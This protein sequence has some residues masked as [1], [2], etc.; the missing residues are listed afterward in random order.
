MLPLVQSDMFL[1]L[2]LSGEFVKFIRASKVNLV[3]NMK[4]QFGIYFTPYELIFDEFYD[5]LEK[6]VWTGNLCDIDGNFT[7]VRLP[8]LASV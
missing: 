8:E 1:S 5:Y 2:S 4:R 3:G 6:S 7:K